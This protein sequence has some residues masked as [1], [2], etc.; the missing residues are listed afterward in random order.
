MRFIG[1]CLLGRDLAS[2]CQ[3]DMSFRLSQTNITSFT[4]LMLVDTFTLH[5][6]LHMLLYLLHL[7]IVFI[8]LFILYIFLH[9]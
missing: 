4:L 2:W 9:V 5:M 6:L 1:P 7:H 8:L 3:N